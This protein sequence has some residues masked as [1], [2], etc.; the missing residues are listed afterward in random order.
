MINHKLKFNC[1]DLDVFQ[2]LLIQVL[3][4]KPPRIEDAHAN[5]VAVIKSNPYFDNL[6][7]SGLDVDQPELVCFIP[8]HASLTKDT[9][10]ELKRFDMRIIGKD[11]DGYMK[12]SFSS[13]AKVTAEVRKRLEEFTLQDLKCEDFDHSYGDGYGILSN[14]EGIYIFKY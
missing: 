14:Y 10:P 8:K 9:E 2:Q 7:K 6:Y 12:W 11:E 5:S 1:D 3:M 4:L 13:M